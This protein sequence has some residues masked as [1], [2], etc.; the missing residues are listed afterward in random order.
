MYVCV[1]Y[2]C[3]YLCMYVCVCMYVCMYVCMCVK[4]KEQWD[5]VGSECMVDAPEPWTKVLEDKRVVRRIV[6]LQTQ[7]IRRI[8]GITMTN[9]PFSRKNITN[10]NCPALTNKKVNCF[11]NEK[12]KTY[13]LPT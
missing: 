3:M 10:K 7:E 11:E 4:W 13:A 8:G 2:V 1:C 6:Y 5:M 9:T 12:K